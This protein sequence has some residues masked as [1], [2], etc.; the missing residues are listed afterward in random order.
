MRVS[1]KEIGAEEMLEISQVG[2]K[3]SYLVRVPME[4]VLKAF[5]KASFTAVKLNQPSW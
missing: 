1:I 3:H 5:R 4:K 2:D